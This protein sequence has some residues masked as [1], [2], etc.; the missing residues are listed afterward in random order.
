[1]KKLALLPLLLLSI[2]CGNQKNAAAPMT[3]NY[4][5]ESGCPSQGK[6]TVEVLKDKSLDVK[7][8][9]IGKMYYALQHTPGKT[10][11]K[12]SYSKQSD[13]ALQDDGYSEEVLFETNSDITEFNYSDASLQDTKMLFGVM[14][15][16]RGKAGFYK[17]T[18]GSMKYSGK[19]L[20]I[21]LPDIVDSQKL[22]D[23]NI[24][25]K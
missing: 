6:C 11:I 19:T 12:Y 7:T 16:C 17:V 10:V 22:K 25:F 9:D 1:M 3:Q 13:P 23:L 2:S 18:E 4:T 5:L 8:D 20:H 14:C 15:F 24:T 21:Q